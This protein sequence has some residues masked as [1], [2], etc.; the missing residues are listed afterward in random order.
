MKHSEGSVRA[1]LDGSRN[2]PGNT[3]VFPNTISSQDALRFF[4]VHA[5]RPNRVTDY[6]SVH[7]VSWY[8]KAC[9]GTMEQPYYSKKGG[10]EQYRCAVFPT[11]ISG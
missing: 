2:S 10:T 8:R 7:S 9:L 4:L 1:L 6:D 3:M 5:R 11:W